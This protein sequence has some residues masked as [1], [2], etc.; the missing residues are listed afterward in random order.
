MSLPHPSADAVRE[1]AARVARLPCVVAMEAAAALADGTALG[2]GHR[3]V[4]TVAPPPDGPY[5]DVAPV[6]L[7]V[8]LP[9]EYPA[10]HPH[11]RVASVFAHSHVNPIGDITGEFYELLTDTTMATA[12]AAFAR[13]LVEPLPLPLSDAHVLRMWADHPP[14]CECAVFPLAYPK[15]VKLPQAD[16]DA[17]VAA[18]R[19]RVAG[20]LKQQYVHVARAAQARAV[21]IR[22]FAP[23]RR[24]PE[25][26]NTATGWQDSWL[27]PGLLA[28]LRAGSPA[29]LRDVVTQPVKGVYK[30][31][32]FTPD[33]CR[34]IMDELKAY[35]DAP[36][37]KSRP[38]SMNNY[39]AILNDIGLEPMMTQLMRRVFKPFAATLFPELGASVDHHHTFLVQYR[40]DQDVSLDMHIDDSEV[41]VNVSISSSFTGAG[42]AFCGLFHDVNHRKHSLTYAH[43]LGHAVIHLGRHRHGAL[44]IETG[45][46]VNLIMWMKSSE[47]RRDPA[48]TSFQRRDDEAPPD[49][50]CLSRTH[51]PDFHRLTSG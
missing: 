41:T 51:D 12:V 49:R 4:V 21:A 34:L 26:Y 28:A 9:P 32:V 24:H 13:M 16:V 7:E 40:P 18:C 36:V 48:F 47:L 8:T 45:E 3:W 22:K 1:D 17:A 25:L 2:Y 46:R 14:T 11:L 6:P 15:L 31:P 38:N 5:A 50:I 37:P 29:A 27:A 20:A 39:G 33:A 10:G 30:F 44:A 42:L 43:E 19:E 23:L 35:E